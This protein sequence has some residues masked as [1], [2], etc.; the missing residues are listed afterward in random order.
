MC[1]SL[2]I[3]KMKMNDR[4]RLI[5]RKSLH[6]FLFNAFSRRER[7]LKKKEIV[8]KIHYMLFVQCMHFY[9]VK[10]K[11]KI[12]RLFRNVLTTSLCC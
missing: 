10:G 2:L 7:H 12:K 5:K 6:D 9:V 3:K 1:I 8:S 11:F 4:Q